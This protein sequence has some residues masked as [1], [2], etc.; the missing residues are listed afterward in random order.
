MT[1]LVTIG[2]S[3]AEQFCSNWT[4]GY[5]GISPVSKISDDTLIYLRPPAIQVWGFGLLFVT[6]IS[7]CAVVGVGIMPYLSKNVY[8]RALTYF[9]GLGVGSLSGSAIF[10]LLPQG[11]GLVSTEPGANHDYIFKSWVAIAGIYLFFFADKLLKIVLEMRKKHKLRKEGGANGHIEMKGHSTVTNG[12][13]KSENF[14]TPLDL[15]TNAT[16][17]AALLTSHIENHDH[18]HH[19]GSIVAKLSGISGDRQAHGICA[20]DHDVQYKEGDSVIA[21]VAWMIIFGDGL[22]N[23]IDGLSI[24]ASFSDSILGGISVSVAVLCEEF[25]HELGD[26]AILVSAG[27]TLRQALTYNL[28]S[29]ASCYLGF[30]IGVMVG[31][32]DDHIAAYV[33]ALAGGMFLYISLASM[34]PEMNKTME[35]EM[36]IKLS[37]GLIVLFL[38]SA[39]VFTGL[40]TMFLMSYYGGEIQFS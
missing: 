16:A 11:F 14:T 12:G 38:H 8:N 17:K 28:L 10:H 5:F 35:E 20:H 24:G 13:I 36:N 39:G 9:V 30:F 31:N 22:H 23:F 34:V 15:E 29:A 6:V 25:P 3:E 26:V 18:G 7:L 40:I 1:S 33:F 4:N 32:I 2:V 21:T 19:N 27:M 37:A